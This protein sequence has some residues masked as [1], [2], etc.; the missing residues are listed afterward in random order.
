[1]T[2]QRKRSGQLISNSLIELSQTE[3]LMKLKIFHEKFGTDLPPDGAETETIRTYY[4]KALKTIEDNS[5]KN[6]GIL[7]ENLQQFVDEDED[8]FVDEDVDRAQEKSGCLLFWR[9]FCSL[10]LIRTCTPKVDD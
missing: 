2:S 8:E 6:Y 4:H 7:Q 5:D 1:M 9:W 10:P 3:M